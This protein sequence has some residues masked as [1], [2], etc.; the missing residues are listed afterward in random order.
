MAAPYAQGLDTSFGHALL[1]GLLVALMSGISSALDA[2]LE[3]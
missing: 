1:A 2:H 3:P